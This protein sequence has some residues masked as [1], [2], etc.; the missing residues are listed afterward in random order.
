MTCRLKSVEL[1]KTLKLK[2]PA[3]NIYKQSVLYWK[4]NE[5]TIVECP[6]KRK[7][8]FSCFHSRPFS[9]SRLAKLS[10]MTSLQRDENLLPEEDIR[11]DDPEADWPTGDDHRL[12]VEVPVRHLP[13][14]WKIRREG[15]GAKVDDY[16]IHSWNGKKYG[17]ITNIHL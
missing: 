7:T 11:D 15:T 12:P 9:I 1:N 5:T 14:N 6:G 16:G 17:V 2:F 3:Y 4:K 10:I 13:G 8:V